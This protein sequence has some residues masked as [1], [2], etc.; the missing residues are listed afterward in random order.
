MFDRRTV[1]AGTLMLPVAA[2]AQ[3]QWDAV[4]DPRISYRSR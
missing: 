4:V 2:R 3:E 1:L